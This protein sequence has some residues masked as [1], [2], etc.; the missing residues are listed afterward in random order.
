MTLLVA[1]LATLL[2]GAGP[3]RLPNGVS[4][5]PLAPSDAPPESPTPERAQRAIYGQ[6]L[7]AL[8]MWD[9]DSARTL[10]DEV[11]RT[12]GDSEVLRE[13]RGRLSFFEGDYAGAEKFLAGSDS[14]YAALAKATRAETETYDRRESAHFILSFPRGKDALLAPYALETLELSRARV[15]ADLGVLPKDKIRVEILRDPSAL[16][17]LS[18]LTEKEIETSGTIALCKYNKLMVVSPRALLTGY[19]W[20][21]TLNHELT[22]YLIT[23][24]SQNKTP[25]WIHE[26][27]AKYEESRWRGEAGLALQPAAAA[28]LS[29][30]LAAGTLIPFEKMHPSMALLP[31]QED[32]SLAFAEVFTII[33]YLIKERRASLAALLTSLAAGESDTEAI[34]GVAGESFARLTH[35]WKDYLRHRPMPKEL[36]PLQPEKLRFKE[37][38]AEKS[39]RRGASEVEDQQL[40]DIEDRTA[41][42]YAHL[43]TLLLARARP[44]AALIEFAKAEGR[45]GARSPVLSTRYAQVLMAS[46]RSEEA[47]RVLRASLTPYPDIAQTHLLLAEVEIGRTRWGEAEQELLA[48]NA[49]DPFDPEIHL[50]LLHVAKE[51]KDSAVEARETEALSLLKE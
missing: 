22:H 49:V 33:E 19:T 43:G 48:A 6:V 4:V 37:P 36:L 18:P 10:L 28:L 7:D 8:E 12:E 26:G 3:P 24:K 51:T 50:G 40:D 35:D 45:V 34:E 13:L 2:L 15:G 46:G 1:S 5:G 29:R 38:L 27:I 25:I 16:S 14:L 11:Q 23:R 39:D 31:S 20:Q 17:R 47:E 44:Q 42:R 9:L 32:A 41:K 21:D 30:R